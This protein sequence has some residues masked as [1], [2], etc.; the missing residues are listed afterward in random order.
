MRNSRTLLAL[1]TLAVL[2]LSGC[3][4]ITNLV[5]DTVS[6]VTDS[7]ETTSSTG[8][9][10]SLNRYTDLVN[11]A[12]EQMEWLDS[13]VAYFESDMTD[14]YEPSFTCG[15]DLYDR[16]GL[17]A[18]TTNPTGLEDSEAT[19]LTAQAKAIFVTIDATEKLCKDLSKYV[20]AKDYETDDYAQGKTLVASLYDSIDEYYSEHNTLLDAVDALYDKYDTFEVDSTDPISVG[21]DNMNK[22]LDQADAILTLIEDSTVDGAFEKAAE[23]QTAYDA[24]DSSLAAHSGSNAPDIDISYSSDYTD[25]YNELEVSFMPTVKRTIR[26]MQ[27]EDADA[28]TTDYYDV[29]DSYNAMVDS[30]NYFLDATGY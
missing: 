15:F 11:S 28:L 7:T 26:D 13:D 24:L 10:T 5:N 3:S 23:L 1:S 20:T 16:D 6:D 21:I 29:L 30:Y 12:H 18:D 2:A 17:E 25:C 27:N 9:I 8:A 22:D 4:S 19:D 14:G